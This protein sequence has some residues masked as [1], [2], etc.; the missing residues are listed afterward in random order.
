MA[1]E[2]LKK[3]VTKKKDLTK[4]P[5]DTFPSIEEFFRLPNMYYRTVGLIPYDSSSITEKKDSEIF[6]RVVSTVIILNLIFIMVMEVTYIVISFRNGENFLE[7]C[8]VASYIG[9]SSVGFSKFIV[10]IM[11]KKKMT[12]LF[13]TLESIYPTPLPAEQDPYD[14]RQYLRY[15][16]RYTKG[17]G[18]LYT[19]LVFIYNFYPIIQ[20]KILVLINSPNATPVLPYTIS[21]PW[22]YGY[23]WYYLNYFSESVAGYTAT[24]GHISADLMIFA[25]TTQVIMHFSRVIKALRE[26]D[27]V[28]ADERDK[29]AD[30][31]LKELGSLV[32]YHNHILR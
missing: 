24:C 25:V 8:M 13:R 17:F 23:G 27:V 7:S 3:L 10:V 1:F 19:F 26:F 22:N 15:C 18:G 11:Q 31:A 12:S 16:L 20:Y 9:F 29:Q 6:L 14:T 5:K 30:A 4:E 2:Y 32:A 28:E 21:S